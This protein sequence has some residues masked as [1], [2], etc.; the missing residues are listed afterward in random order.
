MT[1]VK[2]FDKTLDELYEVICRINDLLIEEEGGFDTPVTFQV[3]DYWC[4][5]QF[6]NTPLFN[7]ECDERIYLGEDIDEYEDVEDCIKRLL[8]ESYQKN[9]S[10]VS[11]L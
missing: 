3:G 10:M 6:Q 7:T 4:E 11:R 1:Q 9:L 8:K 2:F 5:I